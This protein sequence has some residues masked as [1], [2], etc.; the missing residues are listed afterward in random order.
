MS[1][2]RWH[3]DAITKL[4]EQAAMRGLDDGIDKIGET[5]QERV[6]VQTGELKRSGRTSRQGL[7]VGYYYTDSKAAAAHENLTVNYRTRRQANAQAK[8]LE[9]AGRDRGPDALR[10]VADAIRKV[11]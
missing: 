4:I 7:T 6:P 1:G 9:S 3:G 2:L 5:S 8:F 11:L 10:D